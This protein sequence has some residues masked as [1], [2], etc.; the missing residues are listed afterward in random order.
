MFFDQ[1]IEKMRCQSEKAQIG[2]SD[3]WNDFEKMPIIKSNFIVQFMDIIRPKTTQKKLSS[4]NQVNQTCSPKLSSPA[5][6][7]DSS[8]PEGKPL[9][10]FSFLHFFLLK[11]CCS[12]FPDHCYFSFLLY[13]KIWN[14][15]IFC[16][17]PWL[18][19][20]CCVF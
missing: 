5:F 1:I 13:Q 4:L 10:S 12:N 17:I 20:V 11:F 6:D 9:C 7:L 2:I 8:F 15:D 16:I 19:V 18:S 14:G 3:L